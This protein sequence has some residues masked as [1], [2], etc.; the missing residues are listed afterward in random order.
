MIQRIQTVYFLVATIILV[1]FSAGAPI[2][3]YAG[4][5]LVYLLKSNQLIAQTASQ[6]VAE[7]SSK[8]FFIG[9]I[10]LVLWTLYVVISFRNLKKQLTAARIG[11]LLY[12]AYLLII[13]LTYFIGSSLTENNS[14]SSAHFKLGTY[15]LIV[16]YVLY[17][18]GI[19]GIK[20]DKKLIDSVDRIR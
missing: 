20:K 6:E 16:G 3:E 10:V 15:L 18:L 1:Y 17:Q 5:D 4:N 2:V 14:I 12:L 13:V 11:S 8:Y 7:S 9:A 19:Y